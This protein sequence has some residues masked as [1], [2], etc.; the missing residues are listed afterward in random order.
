MSI[1]QSPAQFYRTAVRQSLF[2]YQP[3]DSGNPDLGLEGYLLRQYAIAKAAVANE[4]VTGQHVMANRGALYIYAVGLFAFGHLDSARDV[5]DNIP[6]S[7]SLKQLALVLPALLPG[8]DRTAVAD[9]ETVRAWLDRFRDRLRWN[10]PA[11]RY[12]LA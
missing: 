7:G 4:N 6:A 10:E 8:L 12:E 2:R 11:G 3:S 9:V 1:D 5:I